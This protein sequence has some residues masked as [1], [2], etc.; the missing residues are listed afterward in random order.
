MQA[1]L[2]SVVGKPGKDGKPITEQQALD[3]YKSKQGK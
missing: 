3:F 2:Q 1:Y